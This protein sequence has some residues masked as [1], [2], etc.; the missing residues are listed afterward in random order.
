MILV[1]V[2]K[3]NSNIFQF[4]NHKTVKVLSVST[5]QMRTLSVLKYIFQIKERIIN[6]KNITLKSDIFLT[7]FINQLLQ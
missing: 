7:I 1:T 5:I 2:Q 4:F 6:Q 3:P